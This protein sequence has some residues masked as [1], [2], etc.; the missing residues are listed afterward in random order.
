MNAQYAAAYPDLYNRHW[1]WRVR[2]EIVLRKIR[3]ILAGVGR[4]RILDVGCGAALFFDALQQFGHIEGIESDRTAVERSG[5][6]RSRVVVGELGDRDAAT[7]PFDLILMLDVLEH[8]HDPDELLRR[9]ARILTSSGR[10]LVT[11]P[12]FDWL[13]TAHD[14]INHHVTRYTAN[15]LRAAFQRAGLVTVEAGYMFQSLVVPK[16]LVR[17]KE[18]LTSRPARVPRIPPRVLNQAVQAWFRAEYALAGWLPFGGSLLAVA[19][20]GAERD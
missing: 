11:V 9:A 17:A 3:R 7:I 15:Q 8:V 13:W 6:W 16:L 10:I 1:W 4:A 19:A 18:A 2:E 14:D 12:A 20:P 5:K